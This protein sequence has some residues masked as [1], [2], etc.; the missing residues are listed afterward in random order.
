MEPVAE[1]CRRERLTE[2]GEADK[3]KRPTQRVRMKR[4]IAA[5]KSE[6]ADLLAELTELQERHALALQNLELYRMR[7]PEIRRKIEATL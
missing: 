6:N 2:L 1:A 4:H 7:N 3:P 5:L